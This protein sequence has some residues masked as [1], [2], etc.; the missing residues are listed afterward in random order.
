MF[1]GFEMINNW[2]SFIKVNVLTL[3]E[4][5]ILSLFI[6]FTKID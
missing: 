2:M 6:N 1:D 3:F 4:F 5:L